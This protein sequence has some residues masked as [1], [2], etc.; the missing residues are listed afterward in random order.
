MTAIRAALQLATLAFGLAALLPAADA[1]PQKIQV[2][3]TDHFDLTSGATLRLEH[4]SGIVTIQAWDQPGAEV[5]TI[6]STKDPISAS[7]KTWATEELDQ[8]VMTTTHDANQVVITAVFPRLRVLPLWPRN[9]SRTVELQYLIKVPAD[10]KLIIDH[11]AGEVNVESLV[12][13]MAIKVAD[14]QI[15]LHV[16]D[17][18]TFAIQAKTGVGEIDSDFR[19]PEKRR[20]WGVGHKLVNTSAPATHKLNLSVRTGNIVILKHTV[21]P[22]PAPVAAR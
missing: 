17:T 1:P 4:T 5:T 18:D 19:G 22:S 9:E 21:P 10:T 2:T 7:D 14:G 15:T 11:R 12:A 13:D 3:H 16:P 20:R 8:V 6:K